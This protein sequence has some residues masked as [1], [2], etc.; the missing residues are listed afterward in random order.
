M[1]QLQQRDLYEKAHRELLP[2][3]T[4]VTTA[5]TATTSQEVTT[6][7]L[8]QELQRRQT[9]ITALKDRLQVSQRH[10][11]QLN[12]DLITAQIENNVTATKLSTL[13][14]EHDKLLNRWLARV[15]VEVD[16]MNQELE[17]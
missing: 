1:Q 11:Q 4:S 8:R 12:D 13:R 14:T 16:R 9:E 7:L 10:I 3:L 6:E 5:K 15:S 2:P 17:K